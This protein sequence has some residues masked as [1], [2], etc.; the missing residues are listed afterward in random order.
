[1]RRSRLKRSELP[2]GGQNQ[3]LEKGP[4]KAPAKNAE[5]RSQETAKPNSREKMLRASQLDGGIVARADCGVKR[6]RY[7]ILW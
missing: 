1:V 2:F 5:N 3:S 4:D 7:K 6:K